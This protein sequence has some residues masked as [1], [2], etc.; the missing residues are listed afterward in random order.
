M[1]VKVPGRHLPFPLYSS[2]SMLTAY[3]H[4]LHILC[5]MVNG[6]DINLHFT[7]TRSDHDVK[8]VMRFALSRP[9]FHNVIRENRACFF[10]PAVANLNNPHNI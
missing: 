8:I 3:S 6:H 7:C 5:R 4:G 9:A 1:K 10:S 2:Y